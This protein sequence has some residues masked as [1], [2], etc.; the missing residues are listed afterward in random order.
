[1]GLAALLP[2]LQGEEEEAVPVMDW[3]CPLH[4]AQGQ[5]TIYLAV[6]DFLGLI[7]VS[8]LTSV[9]K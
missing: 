3:S 9:D 1:M 2:H 6:T 4:A 5:G 7:N 8:P